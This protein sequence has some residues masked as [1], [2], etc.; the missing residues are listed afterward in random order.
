M[1]S[2]WLLTLTA[3]SGNMALNK[4]FLLLPFFLF[5]GCGGGNDDPLCCS[6]PEVLVTSG[7][8]STTTSTD[9]TFEFT[10]NITDATYTCW[11]VNG[12]DPAES[13]TSPHSYTGLEVGSHA[14]VVIA[15]DGAGNTEQS[16]NW[17]W[18]ILQD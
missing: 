9:A 15:Q 5:Y 11:L 18:E 7:P 8:E 4:V 12:V 2:L 10:S 3:T 16:E 6:G 13:C 17:I 1:E 14:F